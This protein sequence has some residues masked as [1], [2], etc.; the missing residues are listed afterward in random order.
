MPFS[1]RASLLPWGV[2]LA[3]LSPLTAC[4]GR[5][6]P[7]MTPIAAPAPAPRPAESPAPAATPDAPAPSAAHHRAR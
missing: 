5:E 4:R 6:L 1:S 3:L 2:A 7:N